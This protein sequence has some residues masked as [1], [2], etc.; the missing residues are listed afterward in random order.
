MLLCCCTHVA[1]EF[2]T[3]HHPWVNYLSLYQ[4]HAV[5]VLKYDW[6]QSDISFYVQPVKSLRQLMCI[7]FSNVAIW[8]N[9]VE[10]LGEN[11]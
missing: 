4:L 3:L 11:H 1:A 10:L 2:D 9:T 6:I 7:V 5:P 8:E